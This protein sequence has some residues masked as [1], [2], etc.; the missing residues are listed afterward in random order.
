MLLAPSVGAQGG[1]SL[2]VVLVD[3]DNN[4]VSSF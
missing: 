3:G 1:V 4:D 2:V